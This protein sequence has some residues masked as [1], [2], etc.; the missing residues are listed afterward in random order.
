[1]VLLR[2]NILDEVHVLFVVIQFQ[3]FWFF[4]YDHVLIGGLGFLGH[5]GE[6]DGGSCIARGAGFQYPG[7]EA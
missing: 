4:L 1:M 2:P 6:V 5:L 3:N 7:H